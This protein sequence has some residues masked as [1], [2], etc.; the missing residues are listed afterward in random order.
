MP[1]KLVIGVGIVM[2]LVGVA[3]T[4]SF[5]LP[6]NI[7]AFGTEYNEKT[8]YLDLSN[9]VLAEDTNWREQFGEFKDL[10]KVNLGDNFITEEDRD[11]LK[12]KYPDIEFQAKVLIDVCGKQFEENATELDLKDIEV[13]DNLEEK[14]ALF[15]NLTSVD[16]GINVIETS[17]QQALVQEYPDVNF[18]WLVN[19]GGMYFS[20]SLESISMQGLNLGKYN[21][22]VEGL[23]LMPKL[24]KLDM[25]NT[26]YSDDEL[27]RLREMFPNIQIDWVVYFGK[28]HMRTDR[29]AFSVLITNFNHVRLK[30]EDIQVLKYC[31]KLQALDLGHQ[32]ID[33]ASVIADYMPEMR[34]LILADNKLT[35]ITPLAKLKKLHYLELFMNNIT[36][37]TPLSELDGLVDVNISHNYHLSNIEPLLNLPKLER[38]WLVHDRISQADY[39]RLR[40]TYPNAKISN[41]GVGSTEDGWRSHP[42][43]R[44]YRD[45]FNKDYMSELFTRYD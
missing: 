14:I 6:K 24:K 31:T 17:R 19:L 44:A 12:A 35:D 8:T 5:A 29:I 20:N 42:R 28:W 2:V 21:D 25:S 38:L 45:M 26:N 4:I 32:A 13:C 10:K 39:A 11:Y 33:D 18:Q 9:Q 3:I 37:L 22:F 43:Y 15:P 1:R 30:T 23:K 41:V 7:R 27:G 34:L 36:D 16:L 40:S